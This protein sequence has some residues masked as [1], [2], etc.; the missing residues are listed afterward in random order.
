M[1]WQPIDIV[2]D[3]E[4]P[5]DEFGYGRLVVVLP[6]L[7]MDVDQGEAGG[8]AEN[9]AQKILQDAEELSEIHSCCGKDR[10]YPVAFNSF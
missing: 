9:L 8:E 5:V 6:E 1:R 7:Q 2:V 4:K 3:P 10:I